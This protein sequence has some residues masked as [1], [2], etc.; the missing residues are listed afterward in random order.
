[1]R[2]LRRLLADAALA[3]AATL[4]WT[5]PLAPRLG[6]VLRDRYDGRTQAWVVSWVAHALRTSPLD[7]FQA[8]AF[9][10]ARDVLAFSEPLV[11][12]GAVAVPFS[13]LGLGPV[14]LLNLICILAI[15]F[16]AFSLARLATELGAPRDAA[17]LGSAAATFSAIST[18]Q[19]GFVSFTAWGGIA[20]CVLFALR[21]LR[22]EGKARD[23]VLLALTTGLLGWFSLHLLAFALA[24]L[25]GLGLFHLARDARGTLRRL[26]PL[27]LALA[28]AGLL[29]A[30][31]ALTMLRV[32]AREGFVTSADDAASYSALP[33]SWIA[34][35][36]WNPGQRFLPYRS[37][38]EKAL[39][40]GTAALALA[41]AA[42]VLR[43][44][45]P[46]G[47]L[48]ASTGGVLA[49]VG[50]LGS[51][52][53]HGP[54]MPVLSRVVPPLWGGIRA[55]ARFGFVTQIGVG[56][57]AALGAAR[58]LGLV[59]GRGAR[60]LLSA[61]LLAGIAVDVRQTYPFD[62]HPA[63][64][65][66]VETFLAAARTGGPILHV[67]VTFSASESEVVLDSASHWKPI[68]NGTLSHIPARFFGLADAFGATPVPADLGAR[69]AAWPVGV[70]VV[71][72]HRLPLERRG[73]LAAWLHAE[74]R[75][76]R[77]SAPL[78]FPHGAGA[79][80]LFGVT[81]VRGDAPWGVPG[82]GDPAANAAVLAQAS[83]L[84]A[85]TFPEDSL[86]LLCAIDEPAEG[87]VV[88]GELRARGWAQD[89]SGPAEIVDV[90]VDGDR[91]PPA[92]LVRTPR[93]DAAAAFPKLGDTSSAG[94]EMKVPRL[95]SDIGAA[96]L[97]VRFRA[98]SGRV[99]TLT[100]PIVFR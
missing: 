46:S 22:G 62:Y 25:L 85:V 99:R 49:V 35:T 91:R 59:K 72:D 53:P 17:A 34:T 27:V 11:G 61:G 56:L 15:A 4:A 23:A 2:P 79:D 94:W 9:A 95:P 76:G 28:A 90:S 55:A 51:L 100:R 7:V 98:K 6:E 69:L 3:L 88:G 19:L 30:P 10:P 66:P 84:G 89:E 92:G 65:P 77:L 36:S 21:L 54:L 5:W 67:P 81:A 73:A 47:T 1:M 68:V 63:P 20:W 83:G 71:H 37:D 12:Y 14:A 38:S 60:A 96:T 93:P 87:S 13:L 78:V 64:T 58:L 80:W 32:K 74:V 29:L 42:L 39:Y 97:S 45:P 33:A 50:L 31:L 26:P 86:D 18:V 52:G 82:G 75:A 48:L 70:L 8:N 43:K 24:A 41:L 44:R 16:G 57:L 40:P